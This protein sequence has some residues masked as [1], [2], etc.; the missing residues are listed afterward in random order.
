MFKCGMGSAKTRVSSLHSL[1]QIYKQRYIH[2]LAHKMT[3]KLA[4]R[5]IYNNKSIDVV[6][7][8]FLR[9]HK[10]VSL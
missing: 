4:D 1:R 5:H 2:I 9:I 3:E 8:L 10:R 7:V 6:I